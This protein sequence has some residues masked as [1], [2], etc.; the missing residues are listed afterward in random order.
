LRATASCP[1]ESAS[2]TRRTSASIA[3]AI[4]WQLR[5]EGVEVARFTAECLVRRTACRARS[6]ARKRRTT[7]PDGQAEQPRALVERNFNV[8]APNRLW[9]SD[10][11]HVA[12]WS[13]V[14]YVAFAID[15]FPQRIVG[16]KADSTMKTGLVLDTLAMALWARDHHGQPVEEGLVLRSDAGAHLYCLSWLAGLPVGCRCATKL[17]SYRAAAGIRSRRPFCMA[18]LKQLTEKP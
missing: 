17:A 3:H 14:T 4:F 1:I 2:C 18:R 6:G 15:A 9:V 10:F 11:T 7:I 8:S 13:G 16:W 12:T 5:R